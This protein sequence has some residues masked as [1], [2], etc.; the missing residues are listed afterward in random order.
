MD[1]KSIR[2]LIL[3]LIILFAWTGVILLVTPK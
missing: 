2:E 3:F 1:S